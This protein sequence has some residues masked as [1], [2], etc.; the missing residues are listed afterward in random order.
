MDVIETP[1][2]PQGSDSGLHPGHFRLSAQHSAI[3][4]GKS[5]GPFLAACSIRGTLPYLL[6]TLHIPDTR[7]G[8]RT[9]RWRLIYRNGTLL[10][11][12]NTMGVSL[13]D[14]EP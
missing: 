4:T 13:D 10:Q 14:D 11:D 6:F 9:V 1:P 2:V 3:N 5:I 12:V 7:Q 8:L